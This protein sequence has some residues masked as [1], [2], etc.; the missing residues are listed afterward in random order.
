MTGKLCWCCCT[1]LSSNLL[2]EQALRWH[3]SNSLRDTRHS[4]CKDFHF[5]HSVNPNYWPCCFLAAEAQQEDTADVVMANLGPGHGHTQ[6]FNLRGNKCWKAECGLGT[7][8]GL[9]VCW[10]LY[11]S[12]QLCICVHVW[13]M[14]YFKHH[15]L[16]CSFPHFTFPIPP[17]TLTSKE[18]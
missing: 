12:V 3:I 15:F 1:S 17:V 9:A 5:A 7:R 4:D 13:A 2:I 16:I 14:F 18:Q 10:L 8:L 11:P 6:L